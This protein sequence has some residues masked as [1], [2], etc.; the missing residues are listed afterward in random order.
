MDQAQPVAGLNVPGIDGDDL[1]VRFQSLRQFTI[2]LVDSSQHVVGVGR[3]RIQGDGF[4]RIA[5]G[6]FSAAE[7]H[8][9]SRAAGVGCGLAGMGFDDPGPLGKRLFP[10]IG[11]LRRQRQRIVVLEVGGVEEVRPP[12]LLGRFRELA[13]VME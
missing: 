3:F 7:R 13:G 10:L 11:Q 9:Q 5:M 12:I 4:R 8:H 1:R 6:F 2:L